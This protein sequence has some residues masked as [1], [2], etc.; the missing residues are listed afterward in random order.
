MKRIQ[1]LDVKLAKRSYSTNT[2]APKQEIEKIFGGCICV[3]HDNGDLTC[4]IK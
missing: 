3:L 1:I 4:T 2:Q